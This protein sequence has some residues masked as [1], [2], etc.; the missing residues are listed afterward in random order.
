M[1]ITVDESKLKIGVSTMSFL[2]INHTIK[3]AAFVKVY[4][5]DQRKILEQRYI[6]PVLRSVEV[7][8]LFKDPEKYLKNDTLTLGIQVIFAI[9]LSYL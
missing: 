7:I 9:K 5:G 2:V 6:N 4:K 8:D 3:L 1:I